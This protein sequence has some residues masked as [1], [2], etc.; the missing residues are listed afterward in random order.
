[1]LRKHPVAV[2]RSRS[3]DSPLNCDDDAERVTREE[4]SE[5][6]LSVRAGRAYAISAVD[7]HVRTEA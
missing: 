1:M 5:D 7:D 3:H 2:S 4:T 6:R